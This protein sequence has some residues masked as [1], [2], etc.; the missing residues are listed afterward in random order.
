M[1][2]KNELN[3]IKN[4]SVDSR[5]CFTGWST[6]LNVNG[7]QCILTANTKEQLKRLCKQMIHEKFEVD[8]GKFKQA[9][10][11]SLKYVKTPNL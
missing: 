11:F 8:E 2:N 1:S 5:D 7:T 3:K 6:A 9:A 10:V 4:A